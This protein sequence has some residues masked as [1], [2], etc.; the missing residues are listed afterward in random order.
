MAPYQP[1]RS[2]EQEVATINHVFDAGRLPGDRDQWESWCRRIWNASP[3]KVSHFRHK[4]VEGGHFVSLEFVEEWVRQREE[5]AEGARRRKERDA[6]AKAHAT[7]Q[8]SLDYLKYSE[9]HSLVDLAGMAF[10]IDGGQ[11]TLFAVD[12]DG[13]EITLFEGPRSAAID[14]IV[15]RDDV[16]EI[17]AD[18][19]RR[20]VFTSAEEECA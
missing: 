6:S 17:V 15:E 16:L 13:E 19:A 3:L 2:L 8:A 12:P 14:Y 4:M 7:D 10:R 18:H 1:A 20:Q 11:Y 5:E 9:F